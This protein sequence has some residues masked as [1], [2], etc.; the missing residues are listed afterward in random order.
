MRRYLP[1]VLTAVL[2]L[3]M[4]L[5]LIIPFLALVWRALTL[6]GN[7]ATGELSIAAAV[8]LSLGTTAV[9]LFLT[10]LLGTPLAYVLAR[11]TFPLKRL[12]TVFV[13]LPIVMPPVVAG[14]QKMQ[15]PPVHLKPRKDPQRFVT[16]LLL[17]QWWMLVGADHCCMQRLH[18]PRP[19][20]LQA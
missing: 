5:F 7:L 17:H 9:S 16:R 3:I 4:G 15:T 6:D 14:R 12:L 1:A 8:F 20:F 11:F 13:E 19:L 18:F 10:L 2:A